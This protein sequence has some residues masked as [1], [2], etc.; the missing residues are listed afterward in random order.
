MRPLVALALGALALGALGAAEGRDV[1]AI[2]AD[3]GR[4]LGPVDAL[5]VIAAESTLDDTHAQVKGVKAVWRLPGECVR[6][7][8][9]GRSEYCGPAGVYVVHGYF[10]R[11]RPLQ[12]TTRAGYYLLRALAE[13]IPL[14]PYLRDAALASTLKTGEAEGH[15]VL[16]TPADAAGVREIFLFDLGTHLLVNRRFADAEGKVLANVS[17]ED[18]RPVEGVMLPYRVIASCTVEIEDEEARKLTAAGST[19]IEQIKAWRLR[20]ESPASFDPGGV[21][22]AAGTT[23]RRR[24]FP[25][26]V[27]PTAVAAGDFDGDGKTDFAA[28]CEGGLAVHFGGAESAPLMVPLGGGHHG[29]L[30]V[31]DLDFD[32]RPEILTISNILPPATL[33]TV[34]FDAAR[35][36]TVRSTPTPTYFCSRLAS[37]DLDRDGI[38]DLIATGHGSRT[39]T[40]QF[41]NGA[42]GFRLAGVAWPLNPGKEDRRGLGLAVGRLDADELYEIAVADGRRVVIFQGQNNLAFLPSVALEDVGPRPIDVAFADLNGDGRDDLLVLNEQP[43][44]DLPRELKVLLNAGDRLKPAFEVEAGSRALSLATGDFDGDGK[45]DVAAA[46]F[47]SGEVRLLF[48]DGTGNLPRLE[49]CASGRGVVQAIVVDVN[50][51]G[52]DDVVAANRLDDTITI[53]ENQG[54]FPARRRDPPPRARICPPPTKAEFRLEGLSDPYRFAGEFRLPADLPEPSDVA[55][56]AGDPAHSQFFAISDETPALYRLTL[57]R[58]R[59]RLL[60]SPPVPLHGRT[61]PSR[62]DLEAVTVDPDTG[63]LFLGCEADSTILWVTPFGRVLGAAPSGVGITDNDGL[64]GLAFRRKKDG[65]PLLYALRERMGKS[66]RPPPVQVLEPVETPEFTLR[67]RMETRLPIDVADQTGACCEGDVMFVVTRLAREVLEVRLEG[68]G[69]APGF[70]HASFKGLTDDALGLV[71]ARMPLFGNVE[72]VTRDALGDLFLV[73]DNNGAEVGVP[74]RNRGTEGRLLWFRNE[75]ERKERLRPSRVEIEQILISFDKAKQ[76]RSTRGEEEARSLAASIEQR[77]R[78]GTD[79]QALAQESDDGGSDLPRRMTIVEGGIR[80]L[81]GEMSRQDLPR[82]LARAAF[83]L[84]PGE[85][86]LVEYQE[87]DSPY[88]WHVIRR[89]R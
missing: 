25:T 86:A 66:L 61:L 88:G 68:D 38:G 54:T 18:F 49:R 20:V 2:L 23:M 59:E 56:F 17:Y 14:L 48:G 62:L 80:A 65:S 39:L 44:A 46:S 51:D 70:L 41:G 78:T 57:D 55:F 32:G 82:A 53:F 12:R 50:G 7:F 69:F 84:E 24:V 67:P 27:D 19:R 42:G 47:F 21:G 34:G 29:G 22:A 52:R 30:A 64:E 45:T 74:G 83:S 1:A 26:G 87:Q 5:R 16:V 60:V 6:D 85:I 76:S 81:P 4:A 89:A 9:T 71:D 58:A 40:V 3:H 72:G 10:E 43:G 36:P 13:P 33:F 37:W 31:E 15:E 63:T 35:R 11:Y 77:A 8:P 79:F 28:A 73:V 75:G